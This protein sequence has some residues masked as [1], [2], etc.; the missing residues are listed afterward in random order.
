VILFNAKDDSFGTA[1]HTMLHSFAPFLAVIVLSF[2]L[3]PTR[4]A[5]AQFGFLYTWT[6]PVGG[7]YPVGS[8]WS[9][10][11]VP[12]ASNE[13]ADF[14]L[15][16]TYNV[17]LADNYSVGTLNVSSGTVTF[18]FQPAGFLGSAYKYTTG[19]LNVIPGSGGSAT[20]VVQDGDV[21]VSGSTIVGD[22][23]AAN[24]FLQGANLTS[25][26][27]TLGIS[28]GSAGNLSINPI[29]T[30]SSTASVVLGDS[31]QG[32]LD[33]TAGTH[34]SIIGG[35]FVAQSTATTAGATLGQSLG[36]SGTANVA[37]FWSTGDLTVGNAGAGVI[38][39]LGT[40]I[41]FP[42]PLSSVG[43]LT[44]AN[45]SIAAQPGSSGSVNVTAAVFSGLNLLASDWN[46]TGSLALGGTNNAAGGAGTLSIGPTN[47]VMVGS[48]LK[49]WAGGTIAL[50]E[51][52]ILN[53]TG[54]ANLG[55]DLKFN[56]SAT[57]DPHAGNTFPILSATGGVSGTF[58]ATMLPTLDPGLSWNV[59]YS[60]TSVSLAVVSGV[61]GDF[62][63]NG[64]VD[65]ADYVA[66]RNNVG[67]TTALPN[68]SIGGTI[69]PA[70]FNEWRSH[71]GQTSGS[72]SGTIAADGAAV[73]EPTAPL[74]LIA[75]VMCLFNSRRIR[76]LSP[77]PLLSPKCRVASM[78]D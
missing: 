70:Q 32:Q 35:T 52:G 65:A 42:F 28:S 64:V 69:G 20:L 29:S 75:A 60:A 37:G 77:S 4:P 12:D 46:V 76:E 24:L 54:V 23:G 63:A 73:P 6:N 61:P 59:V 16:A 51:H 11:G 45:A 72:G 13:G 74:L 48:N 44:S 56:L 57:P 34:G 62:N 55:G 10:F 68:D 53:V 27:A 31:G 7:S 2:V 17:Q 67:S 14:N 22:S 18:A 39:L 50:T 71:F 33:M 30:W 41:T 43:H 38:N 15:N 21:A 49:V 66:W 26:T 40:T 9:P 58:A 3:T 5:Y 8:N 25:S 19:G 1:A 36:G 47:S 78:C